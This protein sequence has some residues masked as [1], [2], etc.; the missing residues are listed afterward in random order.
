[1]R[2]PGW[3]LRAT[4][5]PLALT[6]ATTLGA[7]E[8]IHPQ[9]TPSAAAPKVKLAYHQPLPDSVRRSIVEVVVLDLATRAPIADA[10]VMVLNY[11]DLHFHTFSSD[12][13]GRSRIVYPYSDK[14]TLALEIRKEGFVPQRSGWGFEKEK[15]DAP[16]RV[17][18]MLRPGVEMGGLVV[19]EAGR[20]IEGVTVVASVDQYS[21]GK[22]LKNPLGTEILYEVPFRTARDGR[23]CT[24]SCPPTAELVSLQLIHSEF[25]S[26]GSRTEGGPGL[27][28]PSIGSLRGKTDRQVMFKGVR[29]D[30]RV[31]DSAGKPI[32]VARISDSTKGLT[33]LDYVR[34]TK[35]DADGQFHLHFE[36][37]EKVKLTVQVNGFEPATRSITA[38]FNQDPIEFKLD[39]GK[40]IKGRV[41]DTG[42]KPVPGANII[43][44]RFTKHEGVFLRTW[45][46]EQGRFTWGSAPSGRVDFSIGKDG[47]LG[48]DRVSFHPNDEET[49]VV[50]KPALTV[51]LT[52]RDAR[53]G[54]PIQS[55]SVERGATDPRTEMF[56][57]KPEIAQNLDDGTFRVTLDATQGP[58]KLRVKSEGFDSTTS[59]EIQGDEQNVTEVIDLKRP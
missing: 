22:R 9:A 58:Y 8:V 30:G 13:E 50:L 31:I 2:L 39:S 17:T 51:V 1:M 44:P 27:R 45:T 46:D 55:V 23:W 59:R 25:V 54:Q 15:V 10:E 47:F 38:A 40:L 34:H 18:I 36:P 4:L 56:N 53:T 29:V 5:A 37:K 35:A 26:G 11:V 7:V 6:F 48:I 42:G 12:K 41:V 32:P 3:P 16:R 28:H 14:P 57:W 20:P 19:D 33:F 21:P 49:V 24:S 52:V 43:I